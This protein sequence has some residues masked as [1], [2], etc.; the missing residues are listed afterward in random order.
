M[1][2]GVLCFGFGGA[3]CA[4]CGHGFVVAFSCKDRRGDIG[5]ISIYHEVEV[6]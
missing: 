4:S 5:L 1:A 6:A 3:R 2:Y